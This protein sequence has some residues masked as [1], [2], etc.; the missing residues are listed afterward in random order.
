[1]KYERG[2]TLTEILIV[3]AIL[4]IISSLAISN[5]G[6]AGLRG[7][8]IEAKDMLLRAA[9]KQEQFFA[10]YISYTDEIDGGASCTGVD[11][12]LGL[13]GDTSQGGYYK[14]TVEVGPAG[15]AAG[16]DTAPMCRTYTLTATPE[17]NH[18]DTECQAL[19][20]SS[21]GVKG[22]KNSNDDEKITKCWK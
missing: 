11:C 18:K 20:Y 13:G 10:Q 3:V 7:K 6:D 21:S 15:C 9:S 16:S 1:M 8:R 12:G 17:G 19:T 2:F 22:L 14:L 5:F 4:A